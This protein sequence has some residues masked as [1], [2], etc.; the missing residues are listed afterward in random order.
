MRMLTRSLV[1]LTLLSVT[2]LVSA[3]GDGGSPS[4]PSPPD[5]RTVQADPSFSA[6]I[7]EVFDRRGCTQ[8]ACHGLAEQ[9]GLDLR[10]G[11]SYGDLVNVI[12]TSEPIVR[13]IPGNADGSYLVIK[14]EGRQRVGDR[15]PQGLAPLDSTDLTNVKNWIAQGAKNN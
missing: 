7:Q 1:P 9:A 2:L 14:L 3:C 10:R 8:S 4:S 12:A 13:V 5:N 15:M 6:T 11:T